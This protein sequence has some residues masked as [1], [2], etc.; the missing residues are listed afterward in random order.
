M[1]ETL[2]NAS[3]KDRIPIKD[4]KAIIAVKIDLLSFILYKPLDY[5]FL[6]IPISYGHG[7]YKLI[8]K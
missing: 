7:L 6:F 4:I 2:C 1:V 5:P 8:F 3:Y